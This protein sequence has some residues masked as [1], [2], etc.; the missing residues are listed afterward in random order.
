M[1]HKVFGTTTYLIARLDTAWGTAT[2]RI[3][4][5]IPSSSQLRASKSSF[6]V[7]RAVS[8][9][10]LATHCIDTPEGIYRICMMAQAITKSRNT[11]QCSERV[12][13]Q[14]TALSWG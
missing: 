10:Q 13:L 1:A 14:H 12:A 2:D 9:H 11:Q 3:T 4:A 8:Q 7:S 5:G 6:L